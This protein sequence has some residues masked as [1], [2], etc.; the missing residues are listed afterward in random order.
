MLLVQ[1]LTSNSLKFHNLANL[2]CHLLIGGEFQR[3]QFLYSHYIQ[4]ILPAGNREFEDKLNMNYY[5]MFI[6]HDAFVPTLSRR[7]M[8]DPNTNAIAMMYN[9]INDTIQAYLMQADL[10]LSLSHR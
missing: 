3:I 1:L 2:I 8:L 5:R 6:F 4:L 9:S 10:F 7:K